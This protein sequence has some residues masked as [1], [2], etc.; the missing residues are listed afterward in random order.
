M[1]TAGK[2]TKIDKLGEGTYGIVYKA[3][4]KSSGNV[5]ALKRMNLPNED[6]GVPATTIR[7][8]ALQKQLLHPNITRL[9]DVLFQAP[10]LTLVF[11]FCEY[12]LKKY[13]DALNADVPAHEICSFIHQLLLG[14]EHMHT[15]SIVHRDLKPQNLMVT[16]DKVLKIGDFGLARVEG[17]AVKKYGHDAVTLWYRSP[18]AILGSSNYGFAID[19]WSVG[20]IMAELATGKPLFS[21]RS[22]ADQLHR[23]FTLLGKPDAHSW[24][25]CKD[26]AN[27]PTLVTKHAQLGDD[28]LYVAHRD[29]WRQMCDQKLKPKLGESGVELLAQLLQ[30]DPSKRP[31]CTEALAHPYFSGLSPYREKGS[32]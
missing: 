8:I 12:D 28:S 16:S 31:T 27:F 7:E 20:C 19:Q 32:G 5:F 30:Y 3:R 9:Q 24:P 15:R 26:F 21:G 29:A 1:S 13:M 18:D 10:K 23:I 25:A 14:L 17:I 6:E 2:F 22:E 4:E 11:E